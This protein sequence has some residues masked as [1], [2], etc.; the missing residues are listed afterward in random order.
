MADSVLRL[1]VKSDEYDSKLKRAAEGIKRYADEC[2]KVGDTLEILDEGVLD[3]V[4]ALG[5]MDTVATNSK[6]Q[7]REISNALTTLTAT[8][9]ELSEEDK[10]TDFGKGIA[11]GIQQLTERAGLLQDAMTDV[12]QSIRNAASDTRMFDQMA[13][14]MSVVTAGFQ[15]LTGAGKL[16]GIEMGNDIE[17]IAKLQAAMA[18]TN[19]LTTIQTALQKQSTLMQGVM[20]VQAKAAAAAIELEGSATK[21]ATVA[22]TAFN[23]VAKA[24]PYV[25]LATT[26]AAVGTAM[27]ALS[28]RNKEAT[29]AEKEQ[30]AAVKKQQAEFQKMQST[31][32]SA[33]GSIEAKYRSLQQQWRML[34]TLSEKNDFIKEHANAFKQ[35]GLNVSSG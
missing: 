14:G 28:Q 26:I 25:L 12:Q 11:Q 23:A 1:Y 15:G 10:K 4:Q 8:Y 29:A 18:V 30:M 20:A 32:G 35:L 24:N 6:Q 5:K 17:V 19:S 2:K 7:L 31:I 3:F 33:V 9:R 16:L 13:Q 27:Y 34:N 21:G 22:Q